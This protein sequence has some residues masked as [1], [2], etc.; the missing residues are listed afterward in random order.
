MRLKDDERST[1]GIA[2]LLC[3][4]EKMRQLSENCKARDY[5]N[6]QEVEELLQLMEEQNGIDQER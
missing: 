5:S 6:T 3:N 4:P 2:A 1:A